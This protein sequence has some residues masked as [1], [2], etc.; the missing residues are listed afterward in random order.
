MGQRRNHKENFKYFE[1]NAYD[2]AIYQNF[3]I[4]AKAVIGG[5]LIPWYME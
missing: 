2:N 1:L 3:W 4:S 5:K